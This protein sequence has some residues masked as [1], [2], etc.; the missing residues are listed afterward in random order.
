MKKTTIIGS[1]RAYVNPNAS[2][3]ESAQR[4]DI[5]K[6]FGEPAE[7]YVE[8]ARVTRAD[9]IK[10]LRAGDVAA[11]ASIG[12]LAKAIGRIDVRMADLFEARGDIHAKGCYAQD[13]AGLRTDR[14]WPTVKASSHDFFR[15][16]A[17]GAKSAANGAANKFN[18]SNAEIK[19][20]QRIMESRR[21][22]NDNQRIAAI[23]REGIKSPKRTWLRKDLTIIARER[24]LLD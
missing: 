11:V 19:T 24:G 13:A 3:P 10:H 21:Y 18:F 8:S 9:F 20:M 5:L 7:W 4:A 16:Q 2:Y 23:R 22:S 1:V 12:C 6:W 17:Q 15:R 14:E